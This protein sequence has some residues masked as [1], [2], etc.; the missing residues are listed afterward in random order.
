MI[1]KFHICLI[2]PTLHYTLCSA[3]CAW[4]FCELIFLLHSFLVTANIVNHLN[5]LFSV[6]LQHTGCLCDTVIALLKVPLSFQ[7]YFFQKLQSTSIKV[8]FAFTLMKTLTIKG[9]TLLFIFLIYRVEYTKGY[10]EH[11]QTCKT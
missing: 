5:V 7:R 8:T 4:Y 2:I 11:C 3:Q 10:I 9:D 1:T 6:V